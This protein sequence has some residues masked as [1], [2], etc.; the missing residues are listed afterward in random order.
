MSKRKLCCIILIS[1]SVCLLLTAA[2]GVIFHGEWW[3]PVLYDLR[4]QDPLVLTVWQETETERLTLA[5]LVEQEGVTYTETLRLVNSEHPLPTDFVPNV[6]EYNGARMHPDMVEPYIALRDKVQERTGVRIYVASDFRTAE[7]QEAIL[8]EEGSAAAAQVGSSEHEAGLALD[9]Y[10]PHYDGM[11]FLRSRA[12]RMV[13]D[14][15]SDYGFIIRYPRGKKSV[16]GINYEPWHLRYVGQP[17]AKLIAQ[18]GITFEEYIAALSVG[19]WYT[20]DSYLFARFE[21]DTFTL[22]VNRTAC[23]ISP[24]NLGGYIVTVE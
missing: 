20:Y 6:V 17:H 12:G 24:D 18:H 3:Y 7:E 14:I 16:T 21:S 11:N 2:V 1:L 23:H 19:T 10:A 15:C 4:H 13:N 22:P 5:E 8:K 9:V